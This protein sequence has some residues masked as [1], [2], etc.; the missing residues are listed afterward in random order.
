MYAAIIPPGFITSTAPGR[1]NQSSLLASP[2]VPV[3]VLFEED[4]NSPPLRVL[5]LEIVA[6]V[7]ELRHG[8]TSESPALHAGSEITNTSGLYF[9]PP[10]EWPDGIFP[11]HSASHSGGKGEAGMSC[12]SI[13]QPLACPSIRTFDWIKEAQAS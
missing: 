9:H 12:P 6:E 13:P 5:R 1:G 10:A 3:E 8:K 4:L 7:G 11:S 2:S